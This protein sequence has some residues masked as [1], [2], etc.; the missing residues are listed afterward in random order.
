MIVVTIA[1]LVKD[2]VVAVRLLQGAMD[3]AVDAVATR[4]GW[5]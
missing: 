3:A 1:R 2:V 5:M 4:H